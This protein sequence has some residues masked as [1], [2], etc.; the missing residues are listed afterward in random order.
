VPEGGSLNRRQGDL[1]PIVGA[2]S[3]TL[4]T[5][6]RLWGGEDVW[7]L[8]HHMILTAEASSDVS[9]NLLN[10]GVLGIFAVVMVT[11]I[12]VL[13]KREQERADRLENEVTRLNGI[14]QEKT[15]PALLAATE[16]VKSSQDFLRQMEY[17][18]K[19]EVEANQ[20]IARKAAG[21]VRR[22]DL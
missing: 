15:I 8:Y 22:E 5:R 14:I 3:I 12:R 9:T 13:L 18:R 16:A 21:G 11:L 20:I 4:L 2:S 17:Q 1:R 7:E 6:S 19:I 10:Y